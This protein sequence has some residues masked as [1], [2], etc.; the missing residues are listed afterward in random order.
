MTGMGVS[1]GQCLCFSSERGSVYTEKVQL[2]I[3][4]FF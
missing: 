1:V 4:G 3:H 2:I